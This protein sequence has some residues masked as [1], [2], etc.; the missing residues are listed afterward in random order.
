MAGATVT[1]ATTRRALLLPLLRRSA[2]AFAA[3]ACAAASSPQQQCGARGLFTHHPP[4]DFD[5]VVVGAGVVGLAVA[6]AAA[7]AGRS[8]L[9]LEA[10]AAIGAET[11]SRNSEVVHAGIYYP[12]GSLKARLCVEGRRMLYAFADEKGVAYKKL[13]KMIVAAS[14]SQRAQL[15]ALA[16]A[17]EAN[18]VDDLVRLSPA[19]AKALEPQVRCEGGALL[20]PSTG[21]VDSHG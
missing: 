21:I 17:A 9:I 6:R 8:T 12:A 15:D 13:G 2:S 18:G 4:A 19:E 20:S 3:S 10:N 11:S 14:A 16:A 7:R 5:A 1:A